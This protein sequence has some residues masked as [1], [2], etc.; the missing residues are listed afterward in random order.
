[1]LLASIGFLLVGIPLLSADPVL[2]T[3][4]RGSFTAGEQQSL[5]TAFENARRED[6]P[7]RFLLPRLQEGVSKNID[8]R[9]L[10][11]ALDADL[12]AYLAAREIARAVPGGD[13]V[14]ADDARWARAATI[15]ATGRSREELEALV[16]A[17]V[18]FPERFRP[19]T[20]LYVSLA[21]WG[22]STEDSLAIVRAAVVSRI[23]PEN[24]PGIAE[25]FAVARRERVRPDRMAER[26]V[27]GLAR[28]DS[29]RTLRTLVVD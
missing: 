13:E 10:R 22:L 14:I 25:L 17:T 16:A 24:Y 3:L 6:V 8:A 11:R 18:D 19:A 4:E 7:T 1:M 12:T 2:E 21:E 20:A 9:R 5:L 26:I 29:L 28:V 15:M 27:E 23:R